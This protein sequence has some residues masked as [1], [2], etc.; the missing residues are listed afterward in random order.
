MSSKN[1]DNHN[2]WR[3][4]TVSFR[5]SP[6][7]NNQLNT[8][9]KLSGLTKQDYIINCILNNH[10]IIFGN[11]KVY[12]ALRDVMNDILIELKRIEAEK[13]VDKDLLE[14]IAT[15]SIIMDGMQKEN[16]Y[17]RKL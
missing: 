5:L 11:P 1:M 15:V 7:E 10:I 14:I 13:N 17:D 4:K 6:E 3:S 2:R 16:I 12:K 8:K 9:V